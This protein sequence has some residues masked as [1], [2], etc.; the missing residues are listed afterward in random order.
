TESA[1]AALVEPLKF[2]AIDRTFVEVLLMKSKT[3]TDGD[4]PKSTSTWPESRMMPKAPL[5][6]Q[7]R[8][9]LA[10][11][12]SWALVVYDITRANWAV[13]CPPSP[14]KPWVKFPEFR[15]KVVS[16]SANDASSTLT[17]AHAVRVTFDTL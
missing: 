9:V 2:V 6:E 15:A 13:T 1:R 10:P 14:K 17:P 11:C 4:M 3:A 7:P 5:V 8:S 12:S 16:P